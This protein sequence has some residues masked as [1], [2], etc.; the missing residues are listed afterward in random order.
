[1]MFKLVLQA[2]LDICIANWHQ[3]QICNVLYIVYPFFPGNCETMMELLNFVKRL[4]PSKV[5]GSS[6]EAQSKS[7]IVSN[8]ATGTS[9]MV[10]DQFYLFVF[11]WKFTI[12]SFTRSVVNVLTTGQVW[13]LKNF[14]FLVHI[15][16]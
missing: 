14:F 9:S 7:F 2:C 10:E 8:M 1:M 3:Y 4:T 16:K 5:T 13:L 12:H 6:M 15:D 11:I